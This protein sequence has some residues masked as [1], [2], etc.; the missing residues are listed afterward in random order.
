MP[1]T[2]AEL[3]VKVSAD[4]AGAEG[5]LRSFSSRMLSG[6][7]G[8]G[9]VFGGTLLTAG[10]MGVG[11]AVGGLARGVVGLGA[12][13]VS[14]GADFA[15]SMDQVAA[16]L[17]ATDA[18]AAQLAQTAVSLG[19]NPNLKVSTEEAADAMYSLAT[20]GLTT[21]QIVGGAAEATVLLANATGGDMAQAGQ[22]AT[23]AMALWGMSADQ[24]G[25]S[26]NGVVG[27]S[28]A[29]KFDLNDYALALAQGGGVAAMAG[30]SFE[31]FNA[32]IAAT[33]SYFSSGSD[34]G[35]SMKT[36]LAQLTPTTTKA[37]EAMFALG[38]I[39]EDGSNQFYDAEG[40]LRGMYD[41]V[42]LLNGATKDLTEEQ[43]KVA[44][45]TIFG[46]DAMRSAGALAAMTADEYEAMYMVVNEGT[47]ALGQA[48]IRTDNLRSSWETFKDTIDAAKTDIGLTLEV[49]LQMAV[50]ALTPAVSVLA[51][52]VADWAAA[53]GE[54]LAGAVTTFEVEVMP[55]FRVG[56]FMP[57]LMAAIGKMTGGEVEVDAAAR[58]VNVD[59]GD[60]DYSY[61]AK[62]HI[63][64]VRWGDYTHTYNS[65]TH[66]SRV[67][68]GEYT[69]TYDSDTKINKVE[70]G[71]YTASY[72]ADAKVSTVDWGPYHYFY[73]AEADVKMVTWGNFTYSYDAGS[74]VTRVVW[75]DYEHTYAGFVS[76]ADVIWNS[77]VHTY[78]VLAWVK[79]MIWGSYTN[80]YGVGAEVSSDPAWGV[81]THIYDVTAAIKRWI[82]GTPPTVDVHANVIYGGG[83]GGGGFGGQATGTASFSGGLTWVGERGPELVAL[84]G[85]SRVWNNRE[86][87]AMAGAGGPQVVINATVADAIDLEVLAR[88]VGQYLRRG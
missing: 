1:T 72:D 51:P 85:G 34:A 56:G 17:G 81:F 45:Q 10:V 59:W 62:T 48:K 20:A 42:G 75:G 8:M 61:D 4:T 36:M 7:G 21:Q 29:S 39:T 54:W 5:D 53:A 63:T 15:Y 73:D 22:V 27:V 78:D 67:E 11:R 41:I 74:D 40:N 83:G 77:F 71:G 44:L 23:D 69:K 32:S 19:M 79:E 35:T 84:P 52:I 80:T 47:S 82:M 87:M 13:A 37:E 25:E 76:I 18:E 70:W 57:G 6:A 86:S 46:N 64:T 24:L 60:F 26:I 12:D 2:A 88:R 55:A 16:V 49:P 68:W 43:R 9:A 65:V 66:V 31:D 50:K 30:V 28:N 58:V 33:S 14:A 3:I 38:L